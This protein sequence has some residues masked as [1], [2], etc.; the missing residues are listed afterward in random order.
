[1]IV[2]GE[3]T[4][5]FT[6]TFNGQTTGSLLVTST[7][8]NVQTALN[9]LPTIN[10]GG[11]SVAV[12]AT[13]ITV[14]TPDGPQTQT[15]FTVTFQG[16][17]GAADLPQMIAAGSNGATVSVST[18]TDG[19]VGTV[20]SAGAALELQGDFTVTDEALTL[21]GDGVAPDNAGALR[22]VQGTQSSS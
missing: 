10:G 9:L 18:V 16:V 12:V 6:L 4:G 22:S 1:M 15:L 3:P 11:G 13:P 21:N 7:A 19:G 5:A 8:A 14:A 17:A 2:G 20:V